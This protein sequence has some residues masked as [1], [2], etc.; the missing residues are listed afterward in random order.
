MI[1]WALVSLALAITEPGQFHRYRAAYPN[2]LLAIVPFDG[3]EFIIG[4]HFD[5]SIELHNVG[6]TASPAIDGLKATLNGQE[7]AAALKSNFSS[8]D[9]W[10]F[11]YFKDVEQKE[12][13]QP[14]SVGVSRV[15]IRNVKFDKEGTYQVDVTV[16]TE[17]VSAKWIIRKS[18]ERKVKNMVLF[19]GDGMAPS[20]ISAARYLSKQTNFGKFG[21]NLLEM[22]KLGSVGKMSLSRQNHY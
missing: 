5:V 16:G 11:E 9:T 14:T 18:G 7:L 20:M 17:K 19:V 22:E 15:A 8:P 6:S 2:S 4:Q 12:K 3:A 1:K 13:K 21:S 10:S